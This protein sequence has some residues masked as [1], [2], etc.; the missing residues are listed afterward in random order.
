MQL[1]RGRRDQLFWDR[2]ETETTVSQNSRP[3]L[4]LRP[5]WAKI[6]DR[7]W[8]RDQEVGKIRDRDWDQSRETE[9]KASLT[10]PRL[11]SRDRH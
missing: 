2:D 11:V 7:D 8:D 3:R 10:R 6:W 1:L 4:R 5:E 9:T